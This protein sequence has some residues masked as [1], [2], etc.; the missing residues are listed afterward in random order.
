MDILFFLLKN[1]AATALLYGIYVSV[2]RDRVVPVVAR[3][4]LLVSV[5][6][7]AIVPMLTVPTPLA[8][9]VPVFTL[10]DVVINQW[11]INTGGWPD[12]GK[13]DTVVVY[14]Y[15]VG[16]LGFVAWLCKEW[17]Q[18]M[19]M[20]RLGKVHLVTLSYTIITHAHAGPGSVGRYIFFPGNQIDETILQHEMC[21][22][23]RWHTADIVVMR[24][25]RCALWPNFLLSFIL[26][27]LKM[28][29][30]YEADE[31]A[32]H[33]SP[34]YGAFLLN[35]VFGTISFSLSNNFFS[36]PLKRRILMLQ[37]SKLQRGAAR[38]KVVAAIAAGVLMMA[39]VV[40][41]QSCRPAAS[42]TEPSEVPSSKTATMHTEDNAAMPVAK[43]DLVQFLSANIKYPDAAKT[44]KIAGR[45][46]VKLVIDETGKLVETEVKRS[47][48]ELLSA[49]AVRVIGLI[50]GWNPGTKNGIPTKTE[51]YLPVSFVL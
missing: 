14:L 22:V 25:L 16:L 1:I 44:K 2:L 19:R 18:L 28:V 13:Y 36:H 32:M 10:P 42:L 12:A 48:D 4:Y 51:M 41:L 40:Y 7:S 37:K 21:H 47:P 30:E 34:N 17:Y 50:P 45:V 3:A 11:Q 49:E 23:V 39:G 38:N 43:V 9:F 29:H 20:L 33:A 26:R 27:E 46:V 8:A 24:L 15:I 31:A 5:V 6:V 35:E